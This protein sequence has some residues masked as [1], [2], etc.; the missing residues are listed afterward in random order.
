MENFYVFLD[1]D[2]VLIDLETIKKN[3][4]NGIK[5]T[6][7]TFNTESVNALNNLF[8]YLSKNYDVTLVITSVWRRDMKE[9]LMYF[10]KNN[11]DLSMLKKIDRTGYFYDALGRNH[12]DKEIKN[13][14]K[15]HNEK[16]NFVAVDD[17]AGSFRFPD[18]NKIKT[19]MFNGQSLNNKM[20]SEWIEK[21]EKNAEKSLTL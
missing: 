1:I 17:E 13:Y 2:G 12:R 16:H 15:E 7:H 8:N 19:S 14:L 10:E 18:K 6:T 21:F 4:Y 11:I 20:V 5:P 3:F 9:T